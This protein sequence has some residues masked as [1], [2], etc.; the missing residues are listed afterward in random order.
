[1]SNF[2]ET[3]FSVSKSQFS[4]TK[5]YVTTIATISIHMFLSPSC[6]YLYHTTI[7]QVVLVDCYLTQIISTSTIVDVIFIQSTRALLYVSKHMVAFV[8][9]LLE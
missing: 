2:L 8:H 9:K 4:S 6:T 5:I 1:M 7:N 3:Q